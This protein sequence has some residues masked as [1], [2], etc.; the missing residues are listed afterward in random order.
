MHVTTQVSLLLLLSPLLHSPV[1]L[2]SVPK[3]NTSVPLK[4]LVNQQGNHVVQLPVTII[5]PVKQG[6]HVT[7]LTVQ[8][9]AKMIKTSVDSL[10]MHRCTVQKMQL[11]KTILLSH[12]V[13]QLVSMV[14]HVLRVVISR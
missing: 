3:V 11:Q 12:S 13:S 10:I 5:I 4:I 2:I 14:R 9:V 6:S 8:M 1:S 7:V